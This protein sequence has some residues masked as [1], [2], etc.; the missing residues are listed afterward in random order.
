MSLLENMI[1][2]SAPYE[3][4]WSISTSLIGENIYKSK[5]EDFINWKKSVIS[6][7]S[8]DTGIE[9]LNPLFANS[10][11]TFD[12]RLN[13]QQNKRE[14]YFSKIDFYVLILE[15]F[16]PNKIDIYEIFSQNQIT[17]DDKTADI[18]FKEKLREIKSSYYD[19]LNGKKDIKDSCYEN[20]YQNYWNETTGNPLSKELFIKNRLDLLLE[21]LPRAKYLIE[22]TS[23][24]VDLSGLDEFVDEDKLF[25]AFA[26]FSCQYA[27]DIKEVIGKLH[28]IFIHSLIYYDNRLGSNYHKTA[29]VNGVVYSRSD[30]E[31]MYEKIRFE[32]PEYKTFFTDAPVEEQYNL[33]YFQEAGNKFMLEEELKKIKVN[34]EIIPKG[35]IIKTTTD[36]SESKNNYTP[37]DD[38]LKIRHMMQIK[39]FLD[40]SSPIMIINGINDFHG[41]IGYVFSNGAV[42]FEKVFNHYNNSEDY[43]ISVDNATYVM[44]ITNFA[45]LSQYTKQEL[46]SMIKNKE[47]SAIRIM[48]D[49]HT[50]L[51]SWNKKINVAISTDQNEVKLTRNQ[52]DSYLPRNKQKTL[53]A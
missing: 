11:I 5:K 42:V 1:N 7:L 37:T 22:E 53:E 32:N 9:I 34:W 45:R 48:H 18:I 20:L 44:D 49:H 29:K 10:H 17:V 8:K 2:M 12:T 27:K 24:P 41:Y 19:I 38:S 35:E 52:L 26:I 31:K 25:L 33:A 4:G 21:I 28:N 40:S 39:N 13:E 47:V 50:D 43:S 30:F 3:G 51:K 36:E 23:N 6:K 14:F 16:M 15:Q 46:I